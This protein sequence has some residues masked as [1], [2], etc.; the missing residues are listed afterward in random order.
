MQRINPNY[1]AVLLKIVA[2]EGISAGSTHAKWDTNFQD[3]RRKQYHERKMESKVR[4][5]VAQL[6][7]MGIAP[8]VVLHEIDTGK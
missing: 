7:E 6:E 1:I 2:P 8:G 3:P 4:R 5:P